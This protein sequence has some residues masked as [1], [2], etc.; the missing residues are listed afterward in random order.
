MPDRTNHHPV[1]ILLV[2]DDEGDLLLTKKALATS[3]TPVNVSECNNGLEA[4]ASLRNQSPF[5]LRPRPDLI[6]MDLNMPMLDGRE[7]LME[8]KKDESI[9]A[10]PVVILT[11]S[12]SDLDVVNCYENHASC[13]ITKPLD[14][15][16]YAETIRSITDF[17]L[18]MVQLPGNS[19]AVANQ[20]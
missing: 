13:F 14:F 16:R 6:L 17:W 20:S 2:E 7:T 19:A 4:L 10:I 3:R 1:Q 9:A 8:I 5:E 18:T 15:S 12:Q 11:T